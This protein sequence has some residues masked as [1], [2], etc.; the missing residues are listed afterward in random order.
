MLIFIFGI[1][2]KTAPI[3]IREKFFLNPTQQ[4]LLL[5]ELKSLP[6]IVE[7]FVIS[8]CNRTEVYVHS[9]EPVDLK[10]MI[11]LIANI[12]NSPFNKNSIQYFYEH[13]N[14]GAVRHLFR[15]ICGLDSLVLGEKQILG[16]VR[17]SLEKAKARGFFLKSFNTLANVAIRAGKKAQT[18]TDISI[19]GS[20]VSWAALAKAEKFF[21][22]FSKISMLVIG[23]GKM[24]K[25]TVGQ[26]SHK[27][28]QK[29]YL[30]N[31]THEHA[32]ALAE[33][34]NAEAVPFCDIKEVLAQV[35]LCICSVGAP[36][37]ILD[38]ATVAK[39]MPIRNHRKLLL[40]DISMPRNIDPKIKMIDH[41][42]LYSIDDLDNTME[43]NKQRRQE[44]VRAVENV[45]EEKLNQFY[46]KLQKMDES[47]C[48]RMFE[49]IKTG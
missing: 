2:H 10:F 32:Q 15:V 28:F 38:Y 24:S 6:H 35:D 30:M 18:E 14:E 13:Q 37:Y 48:Q 12:K 29:L 40:I 44:A 33:R 21:G 41:A 11:R 9:I 43:E 7:A 1:N 36:H 31:R 25:L 49:S 22:S 20:S 26:I 42:H 46:D 27:G 34:F 5:S 45:I 8:T 17:S 47:D 16:Q 3:E 4:D 23:A 19:G 39:I